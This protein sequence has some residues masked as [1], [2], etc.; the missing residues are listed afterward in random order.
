[1]TD[2]P[3]SITHRRPKMG[4]W[5]IFFTLFCTLLLSTACVLPIDPETGS[6]VTARLQRQ[7]IIAVAPQAGG[8]GTQVSVSGSGWQPSETVILKIETVDQSQEEVIFAFTTNSDG[9]FATSFS[10][11]ESAQW[12]SAG[13]DAG[14][15]NVVVMANLSDE[16]AMMP[17]Q[18]SGM[19]PLVNPPAPSGASS[20]TSSNNTGASGPTPTW[21][22]VS[23]PSSSISTSVSQA[24]TAVATPT[25]LNLPSSVAR[26]TSPGLNIR[27]G[28]SAAYPVITDVLQGTSLIVQGQSP[29]GSWLQIRLDDGIEG[30]VARFFTDYQSGV[31]IVAAPPLPATATSA[32]TPTATALPIELVSPTITEWRGEYFANRDLAGPATYVRNDS[33][34]EFNWGNGSPEA[35]PSDNFSV[36]WTRTVELASD[37]YRFHVRMDDGVRF[38]VNDNLIIDRWR[39]D[40]VKEYT[41]DIWLGGGLHTIRVEYYEHTGTAE[42]AVWWQSKPDDNERT[43]NDDDEFPEWKGE[44]Y[45]NRRLDGNP[46]F[47]RNDREINFN[48]GGG[49]PSSRIPDNDFSVRW[50]RSLWFEE[51][52][53]RFYAQ[54][55]DGVRVYIDGNRIINEWND[56][57]GGAPYSTERDLSGWHEIQV[58]YYENNG[59]AEIRFWWDRVSTPSSPTPEPT[60]T[61]LPT[62]VAEATATA[63]PAPPTLTPT[64][65]LA[66]Q[67]SANVQPGSGGLGESITVSGGAFPPNVVV[68]VHLGALAGVQAAGAGSGPA[69]Y[70]TTTTDNAGSYFVR[71][72]MPGN[73]SGGG[74]IS[75]G[76]ILILVATEDMGVQANTLFNYVAEEPTATNTGPPPATLVPTAT[77]T[78][79][80]QATAT[81]VPQPYVNLSPTTGEK[82]TSVD[83]RGGGFLPNIQVNLYL[84]LFDGAVDPNS[85]PVN[86]RSTV[87]DEN[88]NYGMNLVVPENAPDGRAIPAGAV[89]FVVANN[90]FSLRTSALFNFVV[91]EPPAPAPPPTDTPIPPT[92]IPTDTPIPPTPVPPTPVPPSPTAV[93]PTLIPTDTPT[94]VPPTPVPTETPIP[95]TPV[96]TDT[97]TDV[98]ADEPP[99]QSGDGESSVP[100]ADSDESGESTTD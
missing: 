55:D 13:Q 18:L 49:S 59:G 81:T 3:N 43:D 48:W 92:P 44:Y 12:Q 91:P 64:P 34:I 19:N 33:K 26:V 93:P 41:G 7:P 80:P 54:V 69:I 70:G 63:T 20:I 52:R 76:Q 8:V 82:G 74:A 96:P 6:I 66:I 65:T 36:R 71:F 21:T 88:G 10:Y 22:S 5:V 24:A 86:Y 56:N 77:F 2:T 4:R 23:S 87:T 85:N 15:V 94:S 29:N 38:Y 97:P 30:W 16:R 99:P 35:L 89:L 61:P 62:S 100:P 84:G 46:R 27:T 40:S 37:E 83:I 53:Y 50:R 90:D 32:T 9:T 25:P 17:F 67:A 42:I 39:D 45:T 98:A 79:I 60:V 78:P 68:N 14:Q 58:D 31:S 1:M 72:E 95:P 28:P 51:G 11:P 75:S 73:W 57:S 47:R